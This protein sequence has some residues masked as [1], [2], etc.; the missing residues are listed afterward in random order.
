MAFGALMCVQ[1]GAVLSL[2]TLVLGPPQLVL[3]CLLHVIRRR[4]GDP[5]GLTNIVLMMFPS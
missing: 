4:P 1:A 3:H 2:L 5:R